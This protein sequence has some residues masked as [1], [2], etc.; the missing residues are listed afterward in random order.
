[1]V[2]MIPILLDF[3]F[4]KFVIVRLFFLESCTA[5]CGSFY[6]I[7]INP[8]KRVFCV[9]FYEAKT[10]HAVTRTYILVDN[11][12]VN[13]ILVTRFLHAFT[14]FGYTLHAFQPELHAFF[15][16]YTLLLLLLFKIKY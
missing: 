10:L 14:R 15:S 11:Q 9:F 7:Y 1:M 5:K 8:K 16:V 6:F 3:V 12:H 4:Y 2:S 13:F